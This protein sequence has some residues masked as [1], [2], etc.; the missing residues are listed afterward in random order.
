CFFGLI[1]ISSRL[2]RLKILSSITLTI[3]ILTIIAKSRNEGKS[4]PFG[5]F[6]SFD[7]Q[8]DHVR[9]A[10]RPF[11]LTCIDHLLCPVDDS[12]GRRERRTTENPEM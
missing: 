12:E 9:H 7:I 11:R 5:R 3:L 2:P 8:Y 6:R 10:N 4:A 1:E